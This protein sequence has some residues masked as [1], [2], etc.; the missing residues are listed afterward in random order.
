M[1]GWCTPPDNIEFFLGTLFTST[2][3]NG[4]TR[5]GLFDAAFL[6]MRYRSE[7]ALLDLPAVVQHVFV[8]IAYTVGQLLGKYSKFT[9]APA[10]IS[11]T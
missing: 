2:K 6:V 4:G 7:F 5:P 11:P 8:P 10:P 3:E 1:T 9:D